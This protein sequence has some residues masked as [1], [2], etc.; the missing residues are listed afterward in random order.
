MKAQ[1]AREMLD[2]PKHSPWVTNRD[3]PAPGHYLVRCEISNP[4]GFDYT[5]FVRWERWD[6]AT[7]ATLGGYTVPTGWMEG[8]PP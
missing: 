8:P 4:E 7:W 6:G 2:Y 5:P 3:P 1:V